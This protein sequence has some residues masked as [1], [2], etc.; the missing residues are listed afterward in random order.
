MRQPIVALSTYPTDERSTTTRRSPEAISFCTAAENS[1]SS[2]Y[3]SRDSPTRTT[4]M[5][6][7][8]SVVMFIR[9]LQYRLARGPRRAASP[10]TDRLVVLHA[11][12]LVRQLD[13]PPVD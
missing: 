1:D 6:L 3:M 2:G 5:P 11:L 8:C 12:Q 13:A 7:A 4:A 10:R 9:A